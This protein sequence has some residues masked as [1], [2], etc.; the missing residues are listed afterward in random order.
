MAEFDLNLDLAKS[1]P[2]FYP[3]IQQCY[4]KNG[5]KLLSWSSFW[6]EGRRKHRVGNKKPTTLKSTFRHCKKTHRK[7]CVCG[8]GASDELLDNFESTDVY[9]LYNKIPLHACPTSSLSL[10]NGLNQQLLTFHKNGYESMLK[11]R[12]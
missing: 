12:K 11:S 1:S 8:R 3:H 9:L 2:I 7:G 4:D 10:T 5:N 6:V